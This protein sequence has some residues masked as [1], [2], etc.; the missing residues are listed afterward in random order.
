MDNG[1]CPAL[2]MRA[3]EFLDQGNLDGQRLWMRIM[4]ATGLLAVA[5]SRRLLK[6]PDFRISVRANF[7]GMR[8]VELY[9]QGILEASP[10][11]FPHCVYVTDPGVVYFR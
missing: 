7:R 10:K 9:N 4:Q 3:D 11:F 6:Q 2:P 1:T 8:H 5:D